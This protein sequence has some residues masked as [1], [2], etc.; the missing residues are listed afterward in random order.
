MKVQQFLQ[1]KNKLLDGLIYWKIPKIIASDLKIED[2]LFFYK[3]NNL[4]INV[5]LIFC[6]LSIKNYKIVLRRKSME[7]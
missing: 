5:I 2:D 3:A 1:K 4:V 7:I 6:I